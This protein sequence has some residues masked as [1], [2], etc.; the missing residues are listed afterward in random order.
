AHGPW[1]I[2]LLRPEALFGMTDLD[3]L[4]HSVF[5]SLLVNTSTLLCVSV[6]SRQ[7]ALERVQSALFTEIFRRG[8]SRFQPRILRGSVTIADLFFVA[9]RVLGWAR[10]NALFDAAGL[11]RGTASARQEASPDFISRLEK[12]LAGSIGS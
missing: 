7:S 3:P 12:E 5:W 6:I 2:S 4:V 8:S 11:P 1:G 9:E 10:A